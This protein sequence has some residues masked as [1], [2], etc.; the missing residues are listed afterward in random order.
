MVDI[1]VL[2]SDIS[3]IESQMKEFDPTVATPMSDE[4]K[5]VLKFYQLKSDVALTMG[6]QTVG[7]YKISTY[8]FKPLLNDSVE[9]TEP[10]GTVLLLHGYLDYMGALHGLQRFLIERNYA[11][12]IM[13]LPGHGL[14]SGRRGSI[15]SF[16]NYGELVVTAAD[17]HKKHE[18]PGELSVFGFSIGAAAIL[19][20]IYKEVQWGGKTVLMAPLVRSAKWLI[21]RWAHGLIKDFDGELGRYYRPC[22]KDKPFLK[23]L[24]E[25][26]LGVKRFPIEWGT[27][28]YTW[29]KKIQ[30]A[31][32]S[33]RPLVVIQGTG[34]G[35]VNWRYNLAFYRTRFPS[36]T[37][38]E[39][40]GAEH[41]LLNEAP[42]YRDQA[43][44]ILDIIF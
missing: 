30:D 28:Y 21:S 40:K 17:L 38:F 33:D 13:D 31:T 20:A 29:E 32:F 37:I 3:A 10:K 9:G 27:A 1:T 19:E 25:D 35:T 42:Q 43:F 36:A 6:H 4:M 44:S 11:V 12:L 15:D 5:R 41:H 24:K 22:S 2:E 23:S 8:Y 14:S 7:D 16:E 39:V 26:P 18:L 34:D